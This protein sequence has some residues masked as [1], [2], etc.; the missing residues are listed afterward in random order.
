MNALDRREVNQPSIPGAQFKSVLDSPEQVNHSDSERLCEQVQT[1][2]RQIHFAAFEGSHLGTMKS[3]LVGEHVLGPASFL[4]QIANP[5]A[6]PQLKFLP[7]HQQQFGGTLR[8]HILLI[9][10]VETEAD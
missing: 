7:L 9:R 5:N 3:A 1:R 8:K 6:Q 4:S 10:R 2:K